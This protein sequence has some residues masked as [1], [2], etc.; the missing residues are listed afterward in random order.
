MQTT[1]VVW[2]PQQRAAAGEDDDSGGID[3]AYR[4]RVRKHRRHGS[5]RARVSGAREGRRVGRPC[6]SDSRRRLRCRRRRRRSA[7][8]QTRARWLPPSS[9]SVVRDGARHA[10]AQP[11]KSSPPS[12]PNSRAP[13]FAARL[14]HRVPVFFSP[15]ALSRVVSPHRVSNA[16]D[17]LCRAAIAVRAE[18][19]AISKRESN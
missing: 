18:S 16:V 9:S 15:V 13:S 10:V 5:T 4:A 7:I 11:P 19:C 3:D 17:R 12:S 14:S 8:A 1:L 2:S 6:R